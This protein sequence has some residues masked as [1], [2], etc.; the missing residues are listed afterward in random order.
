[1]ESATQTE[2]GYVD[3]AAERL[4]QRRLDLTIRFLAVL[5][6]LSAL[7][8][9]GF[10]TYTKVYQIQQ[11]PAQKAI[12]QAIAAI[13]DNPRSSSARV[14]LGVLY[15]QSGLIDDAIEQFDEALK[16]ARDDQEAL[17]YAGV[18]YMNKDQYDAALK[19]FNKEIKYYKNTAL[20][21]TNPSLEQAYYYGGVAY[22]KKKDYDKALDYLLKAADIKAASSDT[23][24]LIGRIYLQKKSYE[25]ALTS[26]QMALKLDPGYADALYG[27]GLA[28]EG[29]GEKAK[30]LENFKAALKVR[31][32]F[33]EAKDA[34]ARLDKK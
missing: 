19:Y 3:R 29:K 33:Q 25:E 10:Y 31:P 27:I 24:L 22:W 13:R 16:I 34:V 6:V 32:D 11:T 23:H 26:F 17:L 30:A 15:T 14:R 21:G 8:F 1:M 4:V 28:Y 18:A 7:G 2:V 12:A 5:F 20:A 9:I